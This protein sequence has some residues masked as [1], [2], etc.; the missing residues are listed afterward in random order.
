MKSTRLSLAGM[1]VAGL[2]LAATALQPAMASTAKAGLSHP[3]LFQ[4]I[5]NDQGLSQ[6][7]V[8]SI[9]QDRDG[10]MWFGTE[11]GLNRFDGYTF[12]QF[13]RERGNPDA[14]P[15]DFVWDI[16]ED[17]K[18]DL[19]LAT[20]GGGLVR[21]DRTNERF[22]SFRHDASDPSS[23]SAN[24]VRRLAFDPQGNLWVATRGGGLDRFDTA[25]ET[26]RRYRLSGDAQAADQ[27]FALHVDR[28]GRLWVGGD[29]GLTRINIE[30]E[31][32]VSYAHDAEAAG[33]LTRGSVRAILEDH[34]GNLW[35]GTYGGGLSKL[36]AGDDQFVTLRHDAADTKTLTGDRVQSLFED[37]SQRIWVGTTSGLNLL[38][39]IDNTLVR[40]TNIPA[41]MTSLSDNN[42]TTM[43]EDRS[44]LMWF[45]TKT[46][47]I[48]TWNPRTWGFGFEPA[49]EMTASAERAPVVTSFVEDTRGR[50]WVGTFGDGLNALDRSNDTLT[51]YFTGA[52]GGQAIPGNHVMSLL[53]DREGAVWVGTL[54]NGI[55]R[56]DADAKVIDSLR[57][58][59]D[60]AGSL[61]AN[62]IMSLYEDRAGRVWVGTFGGGVSRY[63][64]RTGQFTN[65]A[66]GASG[67]ESNRITAFA[68]DPS[69]RMWVGTDAGGLSLYDPAT[70]SFHT[71]RHDP[72]VVGTLADD[73]VYD[74][75]VDADGTVWVGTRGGGL[76]RVV[77]QT[78]TPEAITFANLSE[79]DGLGNDTIYG[80][81]FASGGWLWLSTNY[82]ITQYHPE[83][84]EMRKLHRRDGLQGEEFNFGSH[85]RSESGEL[86]FGGTN[87]YNA[88]FPEQIARNSVAPLIALTGFFHGNDPK[89]ENVPLDEDGNV[90]LDWKNNDVGFEFAA[91]DFTSPQNNLYQFKLEGFD[92]EWIDLGN[93]RRVTYTDLSAG[94]YLLRV[95]A[96]NADGAWNEAGFTVP[97]AVAAAPWATWWAYLGYFLLALN[98][99]LGLYFSHRRRLAREAAYSRRLE[100]EVQARTSKLADNNK[101]LHVLNK[102]LQESSLSDPLTGLR[103]RRFVFEEVSRDLEVIQR[104]FE[105]DRNGID[106][107]DAAD[108]VFM[109]I[110]LDHFKPINDTYGHAA[111]DKMLLEL[112][113]LLL[114]T[115]RRSDFV[116]RWGGDEFVVIAKQSR[117]EE[118]TALAER[119]RSR[120]ESRAFDIGDGQTARTTC[121]VGFVAYPMFDGQAE[122]AN[123]D[124]VLNIADSLMYEAKKQRNSWVGMLAP[125]EAVTS[126][127]FDHDSVESTSI[128]FRARRAHNLSRYNPDATPSRAPRLQVV[129]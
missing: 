81:E 109:M 24:I 34:L 35:V 78:R 79:V 12:E 45:G 33:S 120:I 80:V 52:D 38:N 91:L 82:G 108:L 86:F 115:C 29:H 87:G 83:S 15:N 3:M 50:L 8:T 63:D 18:G 128:L 95:R 104:R 49:H 112:R 71:Y 59:P 75:A 119:I 62:G 55:T 27:L 125:D 43:F 65:Y 9:H 124:N 56:I 21:Y 31:Q 126:A 1:C 92:K 129:R 51:R 121:S 127:N 42:I 96:A 123:L 114:D 7:N 25:S 58:N 44:G 76:D 54:R 22:V 94:R 6:S 110:D 111:G 116:V 57:H 16:V 53:R 93:R 98:I 88:F 66:T 103:N 46:R 17:A 10:M 73:S 74:I 36:P 70:D 69:G 97:I 84:G 117:P 102:K 2:L 30:T 5:S 23:I 47:G 48:N 28:A 39:P 68:E 64:R 106:N 14:L 60:D 37:K 122:D 20:N 4:H 100:H 85:Y 90:S 99:A 13:K 72:D 26:F 107:E 61:A 101:E 40:Y 89:K 32:M 11:D 105:N 77:G 113:D 41:E 19:W 67:L 118:A